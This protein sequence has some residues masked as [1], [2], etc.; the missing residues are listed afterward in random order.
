MNASPDVRRKPTSAPGNFRERTIGW[1]L[2]WIFGVPLPLVLFSYI[3][4]GVCVR[5]FGE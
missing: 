2:L 3:L 4:R 1:V 5:R